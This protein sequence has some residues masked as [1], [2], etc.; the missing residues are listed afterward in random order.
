MPIESVMPLLSTTQ[1]DA[2]QFWRFSASKTLRKG[3]QIKCEIYI[4]KETYTLRLTSHTTDAQGGNRVLPAPKT[5]H[6]L[7]FS[8]SIILPPEIFGS[9]ILEIIISL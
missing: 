5:P 3:W 2:S 9:W 8:Q 7:C 6:P 4:W 1:I